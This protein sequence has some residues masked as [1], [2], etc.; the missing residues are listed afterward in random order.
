MS[1]IT[2]R[3]KLE[4]KNNNFNFTKKKLAMFFAVVKLTFA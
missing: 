2:G 3:T 1:Q 4:Y